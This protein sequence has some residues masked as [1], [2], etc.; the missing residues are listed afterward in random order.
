MLKRD[1]SR[2]RMH[3]GCSPSGPCHLPGSRE[4]QYSMDENLGESHKAMTMTPPMMVSDLGHPYLTQ[5]KHVQEETKVKNSN[6]PSFGHRLKHICSFPDDWERGAG[7]VPQKANCTL[8]WKAW[9]S[10]RQGAQWHSLPRHPNFRTAELPRQITHV[11]QALIVPGS[12]L[13]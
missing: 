1:A 8:V 3:L 5:T 10:G 4:T 12:R 11:L 7:K 6:H 2:S 13:K 9:R